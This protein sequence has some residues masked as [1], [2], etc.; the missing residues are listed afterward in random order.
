L[1]LPRVIFA[2]RVYWPSEAAT[3]QLLTDLA[4]ALAVRGWPVHVIATGT[5]PAMRN[6]VT[7]HRTGAGGTHG[8]LLSR[9]GNYARFL[10]TARREISR[11]AQAGDI[12]VLKTDPPLLGA[13]GTGVAHRRGAHVVHWLQDIYPEVVSAHV[14]AWMALS[15]APLRWLRDRAWRAADRCVVVGADMR[16]AV[17]SHGVPVFRISVA[18]NWAP[19]ELTA[20]PAPEA[21]A[22]QR[23][24]WGVADRFVAA[25]SGNLGRVHEFAALLDAAERLQAESDIVFLFIGG[26]A[27]LPEV[28][29]AMTERRLP[30][31][32]FLPAQSR[33]QLATA[34]AAADVHFVT[35]RSGFE[36][37]VSPSKLAGVLAAGRPA[38][39]V[40][41]PGSE[42][43]RLLASEGGGLSFI[44]DGGAAL[45]EAILRLHRDRA[46]CVTLGHAARACY[47]RHF[48]FAAAVTQWDGLLHGVAAG[49]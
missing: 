48:T 11:L 10:R 9:A 34:L 31:V 18:P 6:G 20:Q 17:S 42:P 41:P 27:R 2:N 26:G 4:E 3:A 8:G 16:E 15:L 47:E 23:A 25:Y 24:T 21:V 36:R 49:R 12:V 14:G 7:I 19:R 5:G 1:S 28:R 46:A 43:A 22:A 13:A 44:P 40:G 32:R 45:A 35:L 33:A 37:L 39:Y 38:L 29:R 30:N